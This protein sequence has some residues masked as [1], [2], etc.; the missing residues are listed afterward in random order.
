MSAAKRELED[1]APDGA[2][3]DPFDTP[4]VEEAA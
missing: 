1:E 4:A 2:P 3:A